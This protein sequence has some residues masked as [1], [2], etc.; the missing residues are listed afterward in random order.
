MPIDFLT[1]TFKQ[2][3]SDDAVIWNDKNYSYDWL[4]EKI[5]YCE[6][7]IAS[8]K[9]KS[10]SIV[11]IQADFSPHAIALFLALT[12]TGCIILPIHNQTPNREELVKIAQVEFIY[13]VD[14]ND[15]IFSETISSDNELHPHYQHLRKIK[16]PGLVLFS[17]GTSGKPKGAVHD[18]TKLLEKFK[19]QRPS[20]KILNFLLFDHWGGLNTMLHTLSNGGVVLTVENRSPD[21]ICKFIEKHKIEILPTSPTFLNLL[22]LSGSFKK[23]DL[24][25]LKI[26]SY[27]TE[28]M[29][30]STLQKLY[31]LFPRY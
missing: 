23:Y 25:S 29:P 6:T 14:E 4:M 15:Q 17:S 5:E 7:L 9:L 27:G 1:Q 18:F 24:S 30:E 26:I 2:H 13:R 8:S 20:L 12:K 31:A 19:T 16:H 22:L 21:S 28:P 10:G 11:A 3:L